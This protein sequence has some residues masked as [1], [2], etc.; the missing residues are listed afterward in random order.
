MDEWPV[1]RIIKGAIVL[2]PDMEEKED[3]EDKSE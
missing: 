3:E 1:V 2:S